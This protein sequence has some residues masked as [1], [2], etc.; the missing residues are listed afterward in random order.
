MSVVLLAA[1]NVPEVIITDK[2]GD[3]DFIKVCHS[4]FA[5]SYS[6]S[7]AEKAKERS[8]LRFG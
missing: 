6:N 7:K 4:G 3:C 1:A 5:A 8:K 2:I